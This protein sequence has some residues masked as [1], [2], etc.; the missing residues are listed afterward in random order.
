M[1]Q[2][3]AT[4]GRVSATDYA[5]DPRRLGFVL[6]R[7]KFAAKVLSGAGNVLEIGCGG[8]F[9]TAVVAQE[10]ERITAIDINPE[11]IETRSTNP[12][13]DQVDFCCEDILETPKREDCFDAAFSL[14]VIEHIEPEKE[15]R[16][17]RNALTMLK[18]KSTLI[19]GTPNKTADA[20]HKGDDHIN[21]KTHDQLHADLA[22]YFEYVLMFG[23]NDEV[24]HTGFGPMCHY[25]FAVG[26]HPKT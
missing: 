25:L 24:L 2:A 3:E 15:G 4:L 19:I 14:D 12:Q 11:R 17:Y 6:A 8:G 10:V 5:V 22:E 1:D 26:L 20:F 23:M 18:A 7:Y 13:L 21:L 9:G 16:F